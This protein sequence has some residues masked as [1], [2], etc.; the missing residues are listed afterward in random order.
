MKIRPLA[1][2]AA[3]F[4]GLF[5]WGIFSPVECVAA[6]TALNGRIV[7]L[8]ARSSNPYRSTAIKIFD[9]LL[10]QASLSRKHLKLYFMDEWRGEKKA[11]LSRLIF[12]ADPCVII[13]LG[14]PAAICGLDLGYPVIFMFVL[15]PQNLVARSGQVTGITLAVPFA[16]RIKAFKEV[17]DVK[18][19]GLLYGRPLEA[20]R[21][22]HIA[23]KLGI[24]LETHQL[25]E[26]RY[27]PDA[28]NTLLKN[29]VDG[30][31]MIPDPLL[32]RTSKTVHYLLL[33][34]LRYRVAIMGLSESYVRHGALLAIEPDYDA[35]ALQMV[36]IAKKV[37]KG[38]SPGTIPV[39]S[40]RK[41]SL[42]IN[43]KTA[44]RLGIKIPQEVQERASLIIK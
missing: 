40:P 30:L 22:Q 25:T 24:A 20:G 5:L 4:I 39:Q 38:T 42:S 32:Y 18:K 10:E 37:L 21:L 15:D 35:M 11:E 2:F 7:I 41:Y 28:L 14:T 29:Q 19:V 23:S 31:I 43:L 3:A 9:G 8:S 6:E 26:S 13:A 36:K 16:A 12:E 34:G 33:W 27:I 1:L 17:A 44:E